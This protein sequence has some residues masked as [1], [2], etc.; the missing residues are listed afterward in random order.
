M[1]GDVEIF[2]RFHAAV[3]PSKDMMIAEGFSSFA[4]EDFYDSF[5][6]Q[7]EKLGPNSD[8]SDLTAVKEP[9]TNGSS[10]VCLRGDAEQLEDKLGKTSFHYWA[11]Y[12]ETF[13][14]RSFQSYLNKL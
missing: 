14:C 12:N 7:L 13:I 9:D 1:C 6:E 8:D 11:N 4:V 3:L 10:E 5:M 2:K